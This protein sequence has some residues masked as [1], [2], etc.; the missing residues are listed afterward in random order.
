VNAINN[1]FTLAIN[2]V[3]HEAFHITPISVGLLTAMRFSSVCSN[4][5]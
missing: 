3:L 1:F 5:E 4:A 2:A